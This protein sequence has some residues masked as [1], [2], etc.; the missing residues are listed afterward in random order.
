VVRSWV[1]VLT[2]DDAM[3]VVVV[4]AVVAALVVVI[5]MGIAQYS[6]GAVRLRIT[7]TSSRWLPVGP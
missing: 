3:G 2:A 5:V 4:T 1:G 7:V 6:T